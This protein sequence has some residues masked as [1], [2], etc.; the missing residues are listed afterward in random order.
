MSDEELPFL[1]AILAALTDHTSR[2][3]YADWL[4]E[5][6]NPLRAE[7][8]R[9]WIA[10]ENAGN[11]GECTAHQRRMLELVA[12]LNR[13]WMNL[14]GDQVGRVSG[15]DLTYSASAGSLT[16]VQ[17]G[18][19]PCVLCGRAEHA[20]GCVSRMPCEAC[21]RVFCWQCADTGVYGS[22]PDFEKV[23]VTGMCR[24]SGFRI[25][26]DSCPFCQKTDWMKAHGG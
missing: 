2:L 1:R 26:S 3:V 5:H 12:V 14:V 15:H 22:L 24:R 10:R 4:D 16:D 19:G 6:A 7:Y 13:H 18:Y 8:L 25:G 17:L 21:G 20:T 9:V 23:F 11:P